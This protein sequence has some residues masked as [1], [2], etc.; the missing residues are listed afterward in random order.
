MSERKRAQARTSADVVEISAPG[1][2]PRQR[3]REAQSHPLDEDTTAAV[4]VPPACALRS[5]PD[6]Q[7]PSALPSPAGALPLPVL[8]THLSLSPS[9]IDYAVSL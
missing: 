5:F 2:R 1:L 3:V 7:A 6:E 8:L 4:P 9:S